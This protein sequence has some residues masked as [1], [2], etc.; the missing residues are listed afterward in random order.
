MDTFLPV[1]GENGA[2]SHNND[3]KIK[4][5]PIFFIIFAD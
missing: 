4:T 5:I 2:I 3:D 1:N